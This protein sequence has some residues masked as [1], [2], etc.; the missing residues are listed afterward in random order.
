MKKLLLAGAATIAP[1]TQV[2]AYA[3]LVAARSLA[4]VFQVV[5]MVYVFASPFLW[6]F[7]GQARGYAAGSAEARVIVGLCFGTEA[8]AVLAMWA[9]RR[10][11]R[12]TA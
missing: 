1:V 10:F 3:S 6:L 5:V 11:L 2:Q 8:L 4:S 12:Q 9:C 7:L